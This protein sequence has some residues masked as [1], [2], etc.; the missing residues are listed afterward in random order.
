MESWHKGSICLITVNIVTTRY[1]DYLR[2]LPLRNEVLGGVMIPVMYLNELWS[3]FD[4]L[5]DLLT[6][7]LSSSNK[8]IRSRNSRCDV[9]TATANLCQNCSHCPYDRR[10]GHHPGTAIAN[11]HGTNTSH[12]THSLFKAANA[13]SPTYLIHIELVHERFTIFDEPL[14]DT[15]DAITPWSIKLMD[16]MPLETH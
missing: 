9:E 1:L 4:R 13:I 15:R 2:F 3:G 16:T 14:C 10:T 12:A 8:I 7:H 11:V 5:L 6:I